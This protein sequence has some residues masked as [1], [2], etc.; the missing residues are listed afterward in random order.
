[1]RK[2]GAYFLWNLLKIRLIGYKLTRKVKRLS[3]LWV[4]FFSQKCAAVVRLET[5]QS[6]KARL[7]S[8]KAW[9]AIGKSLFDR[10]RQKKLKP[11]RATYC[12]WWTFYCRWCCLIAIVLKLFAERVWGQHCENFLI[13]RILQKWERKCRLLQQTG[14]FLSSNILI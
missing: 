2:S 10:W 4:C 13:C 7:T 5:C 8:E 11:Q 3:P 14:R 6:K 12:S 9:N 1:M